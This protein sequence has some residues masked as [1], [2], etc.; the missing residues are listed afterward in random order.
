MEFIDSILISGEIF[1]LVSFAIC[2]FDTYLIIFKMCL[3]IFPDGFSFFLFFLP[4]IY[5]GMVDK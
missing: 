1:I 3:C 4:Q 5:W 2:E